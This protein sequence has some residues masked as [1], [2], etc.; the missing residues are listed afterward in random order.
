[1]YKILSKID[2]FVFAALLIVAI[3]VMI[4]YKNATGNMP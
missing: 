4:M 3:I 1:M 2:P